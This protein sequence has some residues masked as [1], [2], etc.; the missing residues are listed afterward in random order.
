M[1][2]L[3]PGT[4][5]PTPEEDAAITKAAMND[6]DS[7]PF[8]DEEWAKVTPKRGRGRPP[9]ESSKELISIRIDK[10]VLTAFRATGPGW[11]SRM[12]DGLTEWAKQHGLLASE[13]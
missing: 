3:K 2:K 8:T 10:F 6:P 5:V 11:Q 7:V 4:V 1:P 13:K 12:N 9:A